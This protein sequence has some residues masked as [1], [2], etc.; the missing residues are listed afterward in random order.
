MRPVALLVKL[1]KAKDRTLASPAL[2]SIFFGLAVRSLTAGFDE[3]LIEFSIDQFHVL[4]DAVQFASQ[5]LFA[6]FSVIPG[7]FDQS[8][9]LFAAFLYGFHER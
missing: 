6:D 7:N 9:E 4:N 8:I 1:Q 5:G 2:Q 3:Q